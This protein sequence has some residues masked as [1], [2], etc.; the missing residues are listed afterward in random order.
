MTVTEA[1]E[2]IVAM[3]GTS[4]DSDCVEALASKLTPRAR[5]I[6]LSAWH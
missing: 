1:L 6:P 5:S 3:K 2:G 4:L